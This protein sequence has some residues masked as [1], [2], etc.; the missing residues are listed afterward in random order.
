MQILSDVHDYVMS[1][2]QERY[3]AGKYN[4]Q[5][6]LKKDY[7]PADLDRI[8]IQIELAGKDI[9]VEVQQQAACGCCEPDTAYDSF[10]ITEE[11]LNEWKKNQ[12]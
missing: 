5:L 3:F 4:E 12:K 10:I 8:Y 7:R 11:L 6:H 1:K 9:E 2:V